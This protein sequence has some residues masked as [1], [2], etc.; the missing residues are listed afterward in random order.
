MFDGIFSGLFFFII[1]LLF[2]RALTTSSLMVILFIFHPLVV[3]LLIA[4]II[5]FIQ[6]FHIDRLYYQYRYNIGIWW[7][8]SLY[9][10]SKELDEGR[11]TFF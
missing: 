11:Q 1:Y 6:L 8:Y 5:V 10:G 9:T 3:L 4:I 2:S 7:F